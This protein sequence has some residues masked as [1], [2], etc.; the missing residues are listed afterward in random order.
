MLGNKHIEDLQL[1]QNTERLMALTVILL[2]TGM[3]VA[4]LSTYRAVKKYLK[5]SLDQ[6]Y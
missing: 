4:L 6:L 2:I 1:I 5:L 3:I